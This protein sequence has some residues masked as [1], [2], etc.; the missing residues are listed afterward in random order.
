MLPNRLTHVLST[1]SEER[2]SIP[3]VI[4]PSSQDMKSI[5][6]TYINMN[7]VGYSKNKNHPRGSTQPTIYPFGNHIDSRP[8]GLG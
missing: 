7:I 1:G 6:Y 4:L 8:M 2:G 3:V 5:A